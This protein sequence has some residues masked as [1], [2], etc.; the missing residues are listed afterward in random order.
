MGYLIEG[1]A[2]A[3]AL[4]ALLLQPRRNPAE[5]PSWRNLSTAGRLVLLL[6]L[7]AGVAKVAKHVSDSTAARQAAIRQ[8]NT[9]ADLRSTNQLL[10]KVMSVANGYNAHVLGVVV[11]DRDLQEPRVEEALR[12]LFLK[13]VA[14]KFNAENSLGIYHGRIDYGAHPEVFR[15]LNFA[16]LDPSTPLLSSLPE[17]TAEERPRSFFFDIRC[18]N[19]KILNGDKIQYV[20]TDRDEPVAGDVEMMPEI[21]GDFRRLY[22]VDRIFVDRVTIEELGDVTIHRSLSGNSA[23]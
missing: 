13:Y 4:S 2:V 7:L 19:L 11:F 5:P 3:L 9:I 22:G 18:A 16:R 17:L 1:I 10:V 6:I 20:R 15:Y 23:L 21:W 8:E 12:N 14:I